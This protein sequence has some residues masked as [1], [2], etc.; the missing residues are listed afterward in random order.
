MRAAI[1]GFLFHILLIRYPVVINV[2]A[3]CSLVSLD[4]F[5]RCTGLLSF[6]RWN[7]LLG[8]GLGVGWLEVVKEKNTKRKEYGVKPSL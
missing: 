3:G 8:S 6:L 2:H 7:V 1:N 4:G 5:V